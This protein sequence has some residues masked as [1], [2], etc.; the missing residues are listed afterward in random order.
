MNDVNI[1]QAKLSYATFE[2]KSKSPELHPKTLLLTEK[3]GIRIQHENSM[4]LLN[5]QLSQPI[6]A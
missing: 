1:I 6:S 3:D 4:P 2:D 5:G